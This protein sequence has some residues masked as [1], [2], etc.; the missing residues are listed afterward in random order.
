[1][2]SRE[3]IRFDGPAG[4]LEGILEVP[5]GEIAGIGV[6]CHPH[7]QHQGTM[8]NKVAHTLARAMLDLNL[9]ALRFNFRGVGSSEGDY[10]QGVGEVAD[11]VAAAAW[12]SK[13]Y[14]DQPLVFGGFSFGARV[15]ILAAT[16]HPCRAL[17]SVA[18]AVG[19]NFALPFEQP[20]VPWLVVQGDE[21]ELVDCDEVVAFVDQLEPGPELEVMPG[22]GHFFHGKLTPLRESVREFIVAEFELR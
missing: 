7:P 18:P 16:R 8:T 17:V 19:L 15:A 21:D 22:V 12:L 2:S 4:S 11:A 1:M 14:P 20:A 6:V 10:D 5:D 9:V 13:L 3:A